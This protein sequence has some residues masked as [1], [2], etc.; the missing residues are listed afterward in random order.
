MIYTYLILDLD[1]HKEQRDGMRNALISEGTVEADT[2]DEALDKAHDIADQ[3]EVPVGV[4]KL[5]H[6]KVNEG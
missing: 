2:K 3:I 1:K 4:R 5:V 6:I